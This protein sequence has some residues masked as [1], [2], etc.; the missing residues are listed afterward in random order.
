V[1]MPSVVE[2]E[3]V[4]VNEMVTQ[5]VT[6][7]DPDPVEIR[8]EYGF[9]LNYKSSIPNL[10]GNWFM[11]GMLSTLFLAGTLIALKRQDIT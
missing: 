3:L 8:T 7:D 10:V 1:A 4:T 6:I 9:T 5:T 2:N 11:L